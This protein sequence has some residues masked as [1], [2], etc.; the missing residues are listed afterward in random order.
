MSDFEVKMHQIRV[1][2]QLRTIPQWA[3]YGDLTDPVA[4]F[5]GHT[6][7]GRM[8]TRGKQKGKKT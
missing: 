6:S 8:R 4:V 3:A 1:L 7:E 5:K 2:L